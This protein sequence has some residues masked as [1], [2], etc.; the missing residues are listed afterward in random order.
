MPVLYGTFFLE[1]GTTHIYGYKVRCKV[2]HEEY[3]VPVG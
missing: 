1:S 3:L 2:C